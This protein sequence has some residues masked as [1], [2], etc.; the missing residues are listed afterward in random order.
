M[1]V[2]CP[3]MPGIQFVTIYANGSKT[4]VIAEV[5][6]VRG[7]QPADRWKT[8]PPELWLMRCP[9]LCMAC[10]A[11]MLMVRMMQ[12]IMCM[13]APVFNCPRPEV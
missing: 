6:A 4:L 12:P 8:L 2:S 10:M 9:E 5:Q 1:N 13:C 7:V 3:M 11:C